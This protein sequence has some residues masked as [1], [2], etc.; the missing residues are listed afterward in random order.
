MGYVGRKGAKRE[1]RANELDAR[2]KQQR[3]EREFVNHAGNDSND[4]SRL[5]RKLRNENDELEK[6]KREDY[7]K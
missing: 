5:L 1:R 3:N 6:K 4:R 2:Y 7:V